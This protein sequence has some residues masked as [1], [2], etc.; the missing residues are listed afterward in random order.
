VELGRGQQVK[1]ETKLNKNKEL[2][3]KTYSPTQKSSTAAD[4]P[5]TKVVEVSMAR[6]Y[7]EKC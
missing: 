6:K 5:K 3:L 7:L 1:Q 2:D 4:K